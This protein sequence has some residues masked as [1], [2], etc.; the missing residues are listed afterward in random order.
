MHFQIQ[1]YN[2]S[3]QMYVLAKFQ[4]DMPITL[5]VMA[6]QSGNKKKGS[7][8]TASIWKINYWRLQKQA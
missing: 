5:V 2:L 7:I 4:P 3:S 8:C 6:L 1:V